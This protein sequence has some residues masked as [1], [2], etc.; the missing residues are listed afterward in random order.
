MI[1]FQSCSRRT[2][3]RKSANFPWCRSACQ[4]GGK[5]AV[6]ANGGKVR[7]ADIYAPCSEAPLSALSARICTVRHV[8]RVTLQSL[9][10][11]DPN[12][13]FVL[14][15]ANGSNEPHPKVFC[16]AANSRNAFSLRLWR[17]AN[18]AK[19]LGEPFLLP[20]SFPAAFQ[21]GNAA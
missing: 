5:F 11:S 6:A 2:P 3:Q 17:L 20:L 21:V 16:G 13:T 1:E 10:A 14:S 18:A 7:T 19:K 12:L 4:N 9:S 15:A 8:G